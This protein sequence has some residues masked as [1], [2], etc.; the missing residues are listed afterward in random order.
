[1][2]GKNFFII[3]LLLWSCLLPQ[4]ASAQNLVQAGET[5]VGILFVDTDNVQSVKRDG[6]FYLAVLSY[7]KFTDQG[8]INALREDEDLTQAVGAVYMYLFDNCGT[9]Y[10]IVS[11][12]IVEDDGK[13]C[14]DLGANLE[15]QPCTNN[16]TMLEAYTKALKALEDKNRW[17]KSW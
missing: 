10:C 13:I 5:D 11:H 17:R 7:E 16:K 3:C 1:M 15:L 2:L 4:F 12:Y 8:Y 14:L 9:K 6:A